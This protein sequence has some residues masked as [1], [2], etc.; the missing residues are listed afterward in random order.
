MITRVIGLKK[1][2]EKSSPEP[3]YIQVQNWIKEK[4]AAGEWKAKEKLP[5]ETD[6]AEMLDISRGTIKQAIKQLMNEGILMQI[7]GKGT[8]VIG[9]QLEYPL[10]ERLISVAETM[11]E[12]Q[13]DFVTQLIGVERIPAS[14]MHRETFQLAENEEVYFL[15]RLRFFEDTPVVFLEN[16]LPVRLFPALDRK[17]FESNT[18]FSIVENEYGISI[19]WGKRS[20]LAKGADDR[21]A[22]KLQ[23]EKG[24]PI[25]M[26]EQ[27]TYTKNDMPIEYSRVWIRNDQIKLTSI[28]RRNKLV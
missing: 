27:T 22:K 2:I 12:N 15:Q 20:F 3:L 24:T 13:K 6:L 17:D 25:T 21:T 18:L 28:L 11:I 10:A 23:I 4:I 1:E 14:K 19:E 16:Y 26:L 5:S 9:E 7:H 8:F